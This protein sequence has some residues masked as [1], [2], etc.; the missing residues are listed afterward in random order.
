[1]KISN[2]TDGVKIAFG[3]MGD[4][5][6]DIVSPSV[7]LGVTGLSRAGKTVFITALV[8]NLIHNGR[9]PLFTA[10]ATGR[11]KRAYLEPQPDDDLPRFAYEEHLK[12]LTGE[13][14][15]WPQST[16]RLSQLRL[17]IEYTPDGFL[18]RNLHGGKLHID[19]IDYPGEWLL[20]LPLLEM[21][22][23]QW[24]KQAVT[25]SQIAPRDKLSKDWAA[26]SKTLDP[27]A[28]AQEADAQKAAKLF[29]QYLKDCRQDEF[30]LS[31][32]PPG[33]F[34]IPGD[35]EDSPLLT[36]APLNLEEGTIA[37]SG[38]LHAMMQRRYDA[39]VDHIVRPFYVNHFARLDRQIVLVDTLSALNAG[40]HAIADLKSALSDIL[41]SFRQ[42]EN[43][44]LSSIFAKRIDKV[45]FAATKADM[46]HHEM[47]DNLESIL[48]LVIEDAAKQAKISGA[49]FD[50][51]AIAALR[52]TREASI[53]HNGE[54]LECITGIPEKGEVID[55]ETFD[56]IAQAAIFPG[57]LPQNPEKALDGSL[58]DA[59]HFVRF[60]PPLLEKPQP[61][62]PAPALPHIRLDRAMQFLLGD[63]FQ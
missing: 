45:L 16:K 22:Y 53:E 56:G 49:A 23:N 48:A 30:A 13:N 37:T 61:L 4:Y 60:R 10:H 2:L 43:S 39:Y 55:G 57:D 41:S 46:L 36:F 19:I 51:S 11:I 32:L 27:Q 26:F 21:S 24:S 8:H 20:D 6:S 58:T 28:E 7:R 5:A 9:L 38:S 62:K 42:G 31:T 14:R 44:I 25:A 47:H 29:T 59:L 50:V 34:L 54:T 33:R 12:A 17:T 40:P 35:L 63:Y 1:M 18:A 15:H 52:A 3:N